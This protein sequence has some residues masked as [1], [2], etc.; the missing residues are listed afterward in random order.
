MTR[1]PAISKID[2]PLGTGLE[3]NYELT[4]PAGE[5]IASAKII[6]IAGRNDVMIF[7][8]EVLKSISSPVGKYETPAFALPAI[9]ANKRLDNVLDFTEDVF[10]APAHV[11]VPTAGPIVMYSQELD[12]LV[13]SPLDNFMAAMQSPVNGEWRCGFGGM[14]EQIPAGTV[15]QFILVSG[16]GINDTFMK[17]GGIMQ[18]WYGHHTADPYA[19]EAMSRIGY[20]TDNGSYY[21]YR[22][23]P[24]KSYAQ[25]LLDVKAYADKEG[26]PYGYFQL[27]SWWYPKATIKLRSSH[28]RGGFMLWE[29]IPELFP[30]G[31]PT[32]RK[33]LDLPL[34]AHNRYVAKGSP[35]CKRY[36]CVP[37]NGSKEQGAYPTDPAFWDEIMDNAAKYGITI[38]EQDWLYTIMNIIPWMRSGLHN[39]ESW[40]DNMANAA[41]KR[42][43][44]IQLCM[45]SPE[46]FMQNL[47][48][49]NATH[50]RAS[51]DYKGGLPKAFFW[52]PFHKVSL[53]AYA[54]GMW[55]F[56]D[57]FQSSAGQHPTY[58]ILPEANP[59]EEA[60]VSS[61]SGGPV[62]PS[63]KIGASDRSL[64]L[65]TCRKDGLLLK[66]D[67]PATPID[68]MFLYNKSNIVG[69]KKPWVVTT[70]SQHEIGKTV[71]LAAFNLWPLN[72]R[73]P[74][75]TFAEA[76][77][78]GKYLIYN[79]LKGDYKIAAGKI[80][81]GIMPREKAFYYVLCPVLDNGMAVIGETGKFITMSAKRFP[82]V[83]VVENGLVLKVQGVPGEQV[84]IAIYSPVE[85]K[86]ISGASSSGK[87]GPGIVNFSVLIPDSGKAELKISQG[88]RG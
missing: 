68:I 47:K 82:E 56:K 66:P 63:D 70:E 74:W 39:A 20:W 44:T 29:P 69:G 48:H 46:F 24:G 19:D 34:V 71:Y 41:N 52:A 72:M 73:E 3:E 49:P 23:E 60:L 78:S 4:S 16:H 54:V 31:L 50:A 22:T 11:P 5:K 83:R 35:Y 9:K 86:N 75:V 30:D 58:N 67:R 62:G 61:L 28:N 12:V 59:L 10:A 88:E 76:G 87:T 80:Y 6:R 15:S 53:F 26:I 85:I 32:F 14:I 33:E 55:P 40:Y 77:V 43:I 45:A 1:L 17:W 21:Y 18:K 27:D 57:N 7:K 8:T 81:F 42:G 38:Y 51:H 84:G 64:I 79:Y 65:R 25:T 36:N 37:D 2:T 13:L